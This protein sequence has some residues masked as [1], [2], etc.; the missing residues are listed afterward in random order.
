MRSARRLL[1][2]GLALAAAALSLAV[3]PPA[4]AAPAAATSQ[5]IVTLGGAG[6]V[7]SALTD[8]LALVGGGSVLQTYDHALRGGLV[9]L[10]D[11]LAGVLAAIP[12]VTGIERNGVVTLSATEPTTRYGLD[13]I[14]QRNRPLDGNYTYTSTGSGVR[15]Y[16]IDTGIAAHSDYAPRVVAGVNTVDGSPSTE[17]CNG[18][19]TH[20]AGTV[21]GTTNGV[22]KAVTLVAVRVF[23]CGNSTSTADIIEGIDWVVAN[24]AAGVP[25]VANMSLGGAGSA[26][27]DNAVRAMI[28]DGVATAVASGNDGANGCNGSPARVAE[29]ITVGATD[30]NDARAS[31]SNFGTCLD[32]H[33]PGVAIVSA[34]P[35]GGTATLSGT[36][37][38]TPH[39]TGAAALHLATAPGS[40][41]AQ[42]HAALVNNA[43]PNVISGIK[44]S[45][46]FLDNLL[47]SCMAGTPNRLLYT[48]SA[49]APPP[50]P[51]PPPPPACNALQQVL[52]LC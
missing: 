20:V 9:E 44:T 19:G 26:A 39:V 43:T 30:R 11:A 36:S 45:C 40:S 18:H 14:D 8:L 6:P 25:A 3:A 29:A 10:P 51:P 7:G 2:A 16:I 52:G 47:G 37:M 28:N 46:T 22:A 5:Y 13:R 32:L 4:Q 24:H 27:L 21:G 1:A 23:G 15:A 33:A 49:S 17:D 50:P 35:G 12:G 48:G 31:F 41:P 34:A 42:V 38:A